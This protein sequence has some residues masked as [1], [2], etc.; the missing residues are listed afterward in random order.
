MDKH[1]EYREHPRV[2]FS[3][4]FNAKAEA[5]SRHLAGAIIESLKRNDI[6]VHSNKPIRDRVRRGRD[7]FVPAVLR[8]SLAQN[9]VLV[10]CSNMA[11]AEDRA[12]LTNQ[13]WREAFS[14]ALVE[15]IAS[16]FNGNS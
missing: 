6:P 13:E 10:E 16:A 7:T 2:Q 15:G 1:Q 9:A 11:N 3:S 5:S 4:T 14:L 12:N 8:Y